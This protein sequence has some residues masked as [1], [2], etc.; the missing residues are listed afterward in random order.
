MPFGYFPGIPVK[1]HEIAIDNSICRK[2]MKGTGD[3]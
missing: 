2:Q 1:D 3:A